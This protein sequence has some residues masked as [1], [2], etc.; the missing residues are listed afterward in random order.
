MSEGNK[1][2]PEEFSK[3]LNLALDQLGWPQRGRI[4]TLARA[5]GGLA[6]ASVRKW[7]NGEGLPEVKRLGELSRLVNQSVQWLLTGCDGSEHSCPP[8][9][10]SGFMSPMLLQPARKIIQLHAFPRDTPQPDIELIALCLDGSIWQKPGIHSGA[11]WVQIDGIPEPDD[12]FPD[13]E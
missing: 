5:M 8:R 2:S 13:D 12:D 4:T 9:P 11:E 1:P 10:V 7:L 6:P 3:N